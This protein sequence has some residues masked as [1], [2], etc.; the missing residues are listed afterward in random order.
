MARQ[1]PS[2]LTRASIAAGIT[3]ADP[4]VT[5][6]VTPSLS[7]RAALSPPADRRFWP[8]GE[9]LPARYVRVQRQTL[10]CPE[11]RRVLLDTGSQAVAVTSAPKSVTWFRCRA[12]GH[13][14][15]LPNAEG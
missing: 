7:E 6:P 2:L 1:K 14:W 8:A 15:K 3:H 4:E 5:I 12:C 11:C 13:R 9:P 10:P